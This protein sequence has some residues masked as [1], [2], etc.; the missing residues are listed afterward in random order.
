MHL[1]DSY[2][3]T[4]QLKGLSAIPNNK[5]NDAEI[6]EL[7]KKPVTEF[8]DSIKELNLN[9]DRLVKFYIK[10]A[11]PQSSET[12]MLVDTTSNSIDTKQI[13]KENQ[14]ILS[15]LACAKL[16]LAIVFAIN[17]CYWMYLVT[18]GEDPSKNEIS[19][20]V[21]RIKLFMSRAREVE[22]S[23]T[24]SCSSAKRPKID[25]EASKRLCMNNMSLKSNW[26]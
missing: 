19:K 4:K 22:E 10:Y 2:V 21:E 16:E 13:K 5:M 23:S 26:G 9:V 8:V 18:Q 17:T 12:P 11:K 15:P 14:Q 6:W 3:Q 25:K 1:I 7:A 20:D 24:E